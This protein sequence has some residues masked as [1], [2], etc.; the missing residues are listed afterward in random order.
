[1]QH[2]RGTGIEQC[3]LGSDL[4]SL[5]MLFRG[6]S[7][8]VLQCSKPQNGA[9]LSPTFLAVWW[10][11]GSHGESLGVGAVLTGGAK[12]AAGNFPTPGYTG[13]L[14]EQPQPATFW[15]GK[16]GPRQTQR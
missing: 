6:T 1:M 7:K 15:V 13:L 8:A 4:G 14:K 12:G 9:G 5:C 3:H 10:A 11:P 2:S 16:E